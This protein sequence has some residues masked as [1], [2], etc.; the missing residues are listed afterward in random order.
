MDY[1][2]PEKLH[3][4][5]KN[6]EILLS[7]YSKIWCKY[8]SIDSG[9]C[10][11]MRVTHFMLGAYPTPEQDHFVL[12]ESWVHVF[13]DNKCKLSHIQII[14]SQRWTDVMSTEDSLVM[15]YIRK[16]CTYDYSERAQVLHEGWIR[17]SASIK[18]TFTYFAS[19]KNVDTVSV[20][21]HILFFL[22]KR[23]ILQFNICW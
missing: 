1:I 17:F 14:T 13:P 21:Q 5:P 23:L 9:Y 8:D 11:I 12:L 16:L 20:K 4:T 3:K 2:F 18:R 19:S 6:V 10:P 22:A 15:S 7:A